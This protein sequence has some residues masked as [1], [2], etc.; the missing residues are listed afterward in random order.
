MQRL[1]ILLM[2]MGVATSAAAQT[3]A[4]LRLRFRSDSSA[5]AERLHGGRVIAFRGP[6]AHALNVPRLA[7]ATLPDSG[8]LTLELSLDAPAEVTILARASGR[9]EAAVLTGEDAALIAED[10]IVSKVIHIGPSESAEVFLDSTYAADPFVNPTRERR[11]RTLIHPSSV[12]LLRHPDC[13]RGRL[14]FE[15]MPIALA[16]MECVRARKLTA[17]DSLTASDFG[18]PPDAATRIRRDIWLT[19]MGRVLHHFKRH[20]PFE[21]R[22]LLGRWDSTWAGAADSVAN[23]R[24]ALDGTVHP[25]LA[26]LSEAEAFYRQADSAAMS[27]VRQDALM[28]ATRVVQRIQTTARR[29][30]AAHSAAV[31]HA[32]AHIVV[33][34]RDAGLRREAIAFFLAR[35]PESVHRPTVEA[36]RAFYGE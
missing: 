28:E 23:L 7:E 35:F 18:L 9:F 16:V 26:Y 4:T 36:I 10:R 30:P 17:L 22:K 13:G 19:F 12:H 6:G 33:P 20:A 32:I 2:L 25:K 21:E 11:A 29:D 15:S 8:G 5:I 3:P 24:L 1:L 14:R 27:Q 34:A 31:F